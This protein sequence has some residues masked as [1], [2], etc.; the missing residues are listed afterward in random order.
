MGT[1]YAGIGVVIRDLVGKVI[2]ALSERIALPTTV[3]DVE[4]L[5]CRRA[6]EFAM[7]KG[8]QQVIF[9]GDSATV[10]N[11]IQAGSPCLAPFG[12]VIEDSFSL[13]SH[14]S[15][16]SFSHVRRKGNVM[17]DKLAKLAK[18][19]MHPKFGWRSYL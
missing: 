7:E 17:A 18:Y 13:A 4:T 9:E 3:D 12:K 14:L 5:A 8:M 2:G 15:H 6:I 11:C 1:S 19:P 10:L 16:Y